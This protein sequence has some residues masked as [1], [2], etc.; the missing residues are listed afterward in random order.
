MAD[1]TQEAPTPGTETNQ[2]GLQIGPIDKEIFRHFAKRFGMSDEIGPIGT[3]LDHDARPNPDARHFIVGL[4]GCGKLCAAACFE[5][6]QS[7]METSKQV[8]KL[9]SVIVD[10][11]LRRRSLG[12]LL[13]VQ[14]FLDMVQDERLNIVRIYAHS[15]HPATVQMLRRLSFNDPPPAGAPI[16]H[17]GLEDEGR[18]DFIRTCE[19]RVRDQMGH[20]QLQCE[21][22]RT[23]SRRSRPWCKVRDA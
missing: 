14:T 11:A 13:V 23:K 20:K 7:K 16:S 22:C 10:P 17:R 21:F 9:D 1:L 6:Y 2:W 19:T 3:C 5:L 15:V 4:H 8:L 12:A 18:G